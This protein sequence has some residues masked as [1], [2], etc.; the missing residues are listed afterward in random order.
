MKTGIKPDEHTSKF[1]NRDV[2][3]FSESRKEPT[4]STALSGKIQKITS[5]VKQSIGVGRAKENIA[6]TYQSNLENENRVSHKLFWTLRS[7]QC[8]VTK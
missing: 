6:M 5:Q 3:F 2:V 8:I 1:Q 4:L 7:I